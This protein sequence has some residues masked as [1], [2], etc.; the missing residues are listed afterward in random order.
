MSEFAEIIAGIQAGSVVPYIGPG[1]VADARHA[2]TGQPMP[3]DSHSLILAMN[4]GQPMAP[5]LMYEFPR[6]AMNLELKRGRSFIERF[7]TETYSARYSRAA[8]HDW[9]K[10]IKP[11]YVIDINRDTQLQ[12]SYADTPYTLI[13]GIARV[14]GTDYR[15]KLYHYDGSAYTEVV[16]EQVDA[17]L[18]I[19]FK[20]MG[21]PRPE[22][23]F[24][25]SDADYVDY[26]TELMG[27]F[28]IPSFLKEHRKGKR[29]L[30]IGVPMNRD[31]ERMVLSDIV[32]GA[33]EPKGWVLNP[34]P[35]EKERGFCNKLGLSIIHADA[36]DLL[37]QV[38][39]SR[40][41]A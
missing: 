2:V 22:P 6:A 36:A 19:L 34:S 35:T 31:T 29:Y 4:N 12:D 28:A 39:K 30:F 7:L 9:I 8:V 26:I 23:S 11:R 33:A 17:S 40:T 3:A 37:S 20:P 21:T 14:G 16:Q 24:I 1:A 25:A 10:A 32:Y 27:G 18:P 15:F 41:A 13:V 5:K 38:E